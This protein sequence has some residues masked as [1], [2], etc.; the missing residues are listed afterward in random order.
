MSS[1]RRE[2]LRSPAPPPTVRAGTPSAA[3]TNGGMGRAR[4]TAG[5]VCTGPLPR[6]AFNQLEQLGVDRRD[7]HVRVR[8]I[9]D[10][11][12]Q[13]QLRGKLVG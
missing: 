13:P 1:S 5:Q 12:T 6:L 7:I 3:G 4:E 11:V 9:D 8:H 10:V 2:Q